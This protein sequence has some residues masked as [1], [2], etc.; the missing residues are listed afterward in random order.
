MKS[1]DGEDI[2][3]PVL[4]VG[5]REYGLF[6]GHTPNCNHQEGQPWDL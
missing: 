1:K 5:R 2:L 6:K 3:I 4:Y